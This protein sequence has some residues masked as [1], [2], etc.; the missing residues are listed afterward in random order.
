MLSLLPWSRLPLSIVQIGNCFPGRL[1]VP[2]AQRT[3]PLV[4]AGRPQRD[5]IEAELHRLKDHVVPLDLLVQ[6]P[7]SPH[8]GD[9]R[10]EVAPS[11]N[12]DGASAS[13]RHLL[14]Y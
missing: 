4:V 3:E 13:D 11:L 14:G 6:R 10:V 1:P 7:S 5:R 9:V 12:L 8:V 2:A